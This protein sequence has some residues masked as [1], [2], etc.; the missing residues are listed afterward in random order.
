MEEKVIASAEHVTNQYTHLIRDHI[1]ILSSL[2]PRFSI[3]TDGH[4]LT[5]ILSVPASILST[6]QLKVNK[7]I[8]FVQLMKTRPGGPRMHRIKLGN[9]APVS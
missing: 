4:K 7:I 2:A 9:K 8:T 6:L 1:Q 3:D 5:C